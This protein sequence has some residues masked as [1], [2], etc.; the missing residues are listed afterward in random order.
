MASG[1]FDAGLVNLEA[2]GVGER[3]RNVTRDLEIRVQV[4]GEWALRRLNQPA[5][6]A[7]EYIR[8]VVAVQ[9]AEK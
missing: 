7:N 5:G 3:R 4:P 6:I 9:S 8:M 1:Q 2:I